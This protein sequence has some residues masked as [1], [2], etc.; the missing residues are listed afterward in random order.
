M[1]VTVRLRAAVFV[2]L[3]AMR[4]CMS[5]SRNSGTGCILSGEN[6]SVLVRANYL[7]HSAFNSSFGYAGGGRVNTRVFVQ[8]ISVV[9]HVCA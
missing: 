8:L 1:H 5:T 9:F 4:S 7:F 6:L 3:V 2:N